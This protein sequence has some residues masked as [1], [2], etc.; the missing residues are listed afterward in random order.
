[1][2][3]SIAKITDRVRK[4]LALSE[5]TH[6]E[7]EAANAAERAARLMEEYEITEVMLRIE[8]PSKRAEPIVKAR[9]E[10]D[11]EEKLSDDEPKFP[12]DLHNKR[13][14]WKETL[15]SAVAK[16]LGVKMYYWSRSLGG[17]KRTDIRGMGRESAIHAWRYTY[18]FLCR[19]VD[20]L[21]EEAWK[22]G[23]GGYASARAWKNAFRVGCATRIAIRLAEKR[24]KHRTERQETADQADPTAVVALAVV[25]KDRAEV[26]EA[27]ARYSKGWGTTSSVGSTSSYDG[28]QA[29]DAAGATASLGG[30]KGALPAGQARIKE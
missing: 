12:T 29:G 7:A 17:R 22:Q 2:N 9:L 13:V 8:D 5:N 19:Q 18:Q 10:P 3:A 21:A 6:S 15:A 30:G 28:Y 25:E 1:M 16:D 24:V 20:E 27:Y 14:A 23:D 4:L 11:E 26:D